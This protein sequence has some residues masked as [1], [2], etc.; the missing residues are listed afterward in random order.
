MKIKDNFPIY[1]IDEL[2]DEFHG[3]IFFTKFDL[4]SG[5]HQIRMKQEDIPKKKPLEHMNFI[6]S[7]W[8]CH[9]NLQMHL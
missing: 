2:L 7:F 5:Y 9:L 4:H 1:I 6:M 3:D 8:L